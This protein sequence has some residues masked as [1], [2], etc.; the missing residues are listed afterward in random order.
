MTAAA[1]TAWPGSGSSFRS[2]MSQMP[3][4]PG[5]TAMEIFLTMVCPGTNRPKG[6]G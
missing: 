1:Q 4:R 3:N 6:V 2:V 5:L